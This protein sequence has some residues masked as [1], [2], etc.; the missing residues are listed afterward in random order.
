MQLELQYESV[1][2]FCRPFIAPTSM[3]H[4]AAQEKGLALS[5]SFFT[6]IVR[7]IL[8]NHFPSVFTDGNYCACLIGNG[9]EVLGY[10]NAMSQDHDFGP[11]VQIL[12]TSEDYV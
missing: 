3:S 2:Q 5:R 6:E 4:S 10:D 1:D 8:I 9:S 11:R 7:P 12:L